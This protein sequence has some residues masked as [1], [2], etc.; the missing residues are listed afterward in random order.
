LPRTDLVHFFV[1][2]AEN[3]GGIAASADWASVTRVVGD[4]MEPQGLYPERYRVRD[5]PSEEQLRLLG[6]R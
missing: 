3:E 5:F 1:P 2:K 6:G 4:L